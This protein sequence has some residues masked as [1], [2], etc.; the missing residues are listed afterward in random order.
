[1]QRLRAVRDEFTQMGAIT[2]AALVTLDLME[3]Y[4]AL[5]KPTEARRAAGN[6][7]ALFT[8]VG[9]LTGAV[10][11]ANWL[12]QAAA[13]R[14]VTPSILDAIRRYLRRVDLQPDFAFV[15]PAL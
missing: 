8:E 9:M 11:A 10:V 2:D 15:P 12:K 1:V 7:V 3:T 4:L 6:I 5:R 14:R 13:A